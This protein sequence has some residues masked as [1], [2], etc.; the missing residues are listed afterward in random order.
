MKDKNYQKEMMFETLFGFRKISSSCI[1]I[2]PINKIYLEIKNNFN[3]IEETLGWWKRAIIQTDSHFVEILKIPSGPYIKDC[4]KV[5]DLERAEKIILLG[6]CASLRSNLEIGS[7]I[8]PYKACHRSA[9][10]CTT[11]LFIGTKKAKIGTVFQMTTS[12]KKLKRICE[13]RADIIDM[14][15]YFLYKFGCLKG[16]SVYSLL[17]IT[18]N[19]FTT[20]FY[21]LN[22]KEKRN[23][24]KG[25]KGAIEILK[26]QIL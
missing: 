16:V 12:K 1:V 3:V 24:E 15:T 7:V 25:I 14:E 26:K 18:D 11:P 20:P 17:V 9:V 23:I 4:L 10:F 13:G 22:K 5:L 21:K 8:S 6:Y 2:T 19:P